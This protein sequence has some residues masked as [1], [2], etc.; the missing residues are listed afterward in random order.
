MA[1]LDQLQ[2]WVAETQS[3]N[4]TWPASWQW[5]LVSGD[6]SFRKYYRVIKEDGT[7]IIAVD[8]PPAQENNPAFV[9]LACH[10][11]EKGMRL[12]E[13]LATNFE[14]GY[15]LVEDFGDVMLR[16]RLSAA[17]VDGWY[18]QA[19]ALLPSLQQIDDCQDYPLP[20]YDRAM[21]ERELEI[22]AEWFYRGL[23]QLPETSQTQHVW[24]ELCQQ[25]V[26]AMLVQPQVC[27]HRDFHSRNLMCL[28]EG[29]L[30]VIDFQ[31]A[32][33]GPVSYDVVSLIRDCYL[34]WPASQVMCWSEYAYGL[35]RQQ[36]PSVLQ[37]VSLTLWQRWLDLTGMQR[38]LKAI[39]IF[40]RLHLRDGKSAYL[41]DIPRTLGYVLEQAQRYA[42]F[43]PF[44]HLLL[45]QVVP[46]LR[47][48]SLISVEAQKDLTT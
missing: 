26:Q 40:A 38:H 10:W 30:G 41:Q 45:D 44:T 2:S 3:G 8:A 23:L 32:V 17:T 29:R 35:L 22:Y 27:I 19:L 48:C 43:E 46:A 5:Q 16:D 39:G 20:C 12:P 37:D 28:P 18:Q 15:L 13:I 36:Q 24:R 7:A 21:L 47:E 31:G 34:R 11:R 9:A 42:E 6:A 4:Q 33:R 14:Q 25:L 1:R